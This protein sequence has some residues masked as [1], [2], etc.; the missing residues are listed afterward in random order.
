M[1]DL[2]EITGTSRVTFSNG[3]W[4]VDGKVVSPDELASMLP[5]DRDAYV[6]KL[7]DRAQ[8]SGDLTPGQLAAADIESL[9]DEQLQERADASAERLGLSSE[10]AGSLRAMLEAAGVD[11]DKPEVQ[12]YMQDRQALLD[13]EQMQLSELEAEVASLTVMHPA[14]PAS[15]YSQALEDS[16]FGD[17]PFYAPAAVEGPGITRPGMGQFIQ[18]D[19][20]AREYQLQPDTGWIRYENGVLVSPDGQVAYDPKSRAPG[21]LAWFREKV[22]DWDE[23]KVREWRNT[24]HEFGYLAEDETK[25]GSADLVFREAL[26]KYHAARYVNGGKPVMD[27]ASMARAARPRRRPSTSETSRPRSGTTSGTST[28]GSTARSRVMARSSCGRTTS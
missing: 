10:G 12:I 18:A 24:L 25:S 20:T 16:G 22:N 8:R 7:K 26:A 27:D 11:L 3:V 23:D 28:S 2:P 6:T 14:I 1:A 4:R 13:N 5:A 21:S 19:P 9:T 17:D 15:V